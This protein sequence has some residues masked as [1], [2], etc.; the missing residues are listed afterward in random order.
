MDKNDQMISLLI[1][2]LLI[3]EQ[4]SHFQPKKEEIPLCPPVRKD[5]EVESQLKRNKRFI[6]KDETF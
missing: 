5:P 6:N 1:R 3:A 4:M 2:N